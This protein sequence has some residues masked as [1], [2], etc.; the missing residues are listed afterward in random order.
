MLTFVLSA[1]MP[2]SLIIMTTFWL[3]FEPII[4]LLNNPSSKLPWMHTS[5]ATWT[6]QMEME[7][8]R[9]IRRMS[10]MRWWQMS[11]IRRVELLGAW[12]IKWMLKRL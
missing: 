8:S 9:C 2:T 1:R 3:D 10:L 7:T 5:W 11:R 12:L 4:S 6:A